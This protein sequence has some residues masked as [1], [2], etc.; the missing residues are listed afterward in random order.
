MSFMMIKIN[1]E[2]KKISLSD[3]LYIKSH[4]YKPHYVQIVTETESYD[5][6]Q[7]LQNL[8]ELYPKYFI[9]CHRS[10]LVNSSKIKAVNVRENRI[11]LG[12][13]EQHQVTF[14]RRKKQQILQEW[15][16]KGEV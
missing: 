4:S 9:R 8:E 15:L 11:I 5:L 6:G 3:I 7:T 12:E 10:C 1:D 16:D 14:S 13:K 2:I